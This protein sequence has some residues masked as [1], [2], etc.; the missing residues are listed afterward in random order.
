MTS[1]HPPRFRVGRVGRRLATAVAALT[2]LFSSPDVSAQGTVD[3]PDFSGSWQRDP[4]QSE[5]PR[6]QS[7]RQ[8]NR[9]RFRGPWSR[10]S[11]PAGPDPGSRIG[12]GQTP[13]PGY[14][15]QAG[16]G[17]QGGR[18]GRR[19]AAGQGQRPADLL[20]GLDRLRIEHRD[21]ELLVHLSDDTTRLLFTDGRRST[22]ADG[23]GSQTARFEDGALVVVTDG[24]RGRRS[25]RWELSWSGN[26][27]FVTTE[28]ES[29]E[30]GSSWAFRTTYER[31]D[32][33]PSRQPTEAASA[34]T[35]TGPDPASG[36]SAPTAT[37]A[38]PRPPPQPD[39]EMGLPAR[40]AK[41]RGAV[42][43]VLP[44]KASPGT[45]L[46]GRVLVQTL[47]MDPDIQRVDFLLDDEPVASRKLPPFEARVTLASPPREQV[48]RAVAYS[49][50][51]R[52]LGA[53][54]IVLNLV[55]PPFRARITEIADGSRPGSLAVSAEVSVPRKAELLELAFYR[56]QELVA[57]LTEAPFRVEMQA[58]RS[59]QGFVRVEA[60]LRDGRRIE[61]VELLQPAGFSE[62]VD[63][64]LVQLQVLVTDK[65]GAPITG[66]GPED[67]EIVE[68]G[69]KREIQRLY[70][71]DDVALNLGL[72]VDSSGSMG[73]LWQQTRG[74][75]RQFLQS[76]LL[77]RDRAF[78]VDFDTRLRLL[79][80]LTADK[81]SLYA[82][83]GKL[84]PE[85]GTALYDSI[86]FSLLQY[87]GEPGRRA[88][89]VLSDGFDSGSKADPNRAVEFGQRLGVPVYVIAMSSR[90]SAASGMGRRGPPGSTGPG[91]FSASAGMQEGLARANLRLITK[92]TGGRLF[93]VVSVD[94][95]PR[96][97]A[98]IQD[99]LRKQYVLTYYTE[100]APTER[101]P[102]V[103]VLRKGLKV[104]AALPLDQVN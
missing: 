84:S 4:E 94:Q 100:T 7:R 29:P 28:I 67:F 10:G 39:P 36:A 71:A 50:G 104:K 9:G 96:A 85:G 14:G 47:T 73:P 93:Q 27:L 61:D 13:P 72:A 98:Q 5:D 56:G 37:T 32:D 1:V 62:E 90:G 65:S 18:Q 21:P 35:P 74:S 19:G 80:P 79:Q 24:E 89:I 42:L 11:R 76:T 66:L 41:A 88:L 52:E 64:Q 95:V 25:E 45:Q 83:L 20:S 8:G 16:Q 57:T 12:R 3:N 103:K 101:A 63:V 99:E 33:D 43:R 46:S 75:A 22:T 78:V 91:G 6:V 81:A 17:S 30:T 38:A 49:A 44:L 51:G 58:D 48:L 69:E 92:P 59:A 86:L 70:V 23:S 53:D 87:D 54:Q 40:D 55:D 15:G 97:F 2:L 31:I 34:S 82:A 102:V 26:R 60:V 77:P 68:G